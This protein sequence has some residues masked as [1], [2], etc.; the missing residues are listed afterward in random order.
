MKI[1][2]VSGFLGAGKTTFIEKMTKKIN[3]EFVV[4]ENEYGEVGIDGD[5]LKRDYDKVWEMTEGCIC[6]SMKSDF[7]NS[8]MTIS[9]AVDPDVLIVEPTGVGMLSSVMNNIKKVEYDRIQILEPIT[10]VDPNC[11][12]IYKEEF[13]D[14][15]TDQIKSSNMIIISK[16]ENLDGPAIE[17]AK[18]YVSDINPDAEIFTGDYS[19]YDDIWWEEILQK[20]W[21]SREDKVKE[22]FVDSKIENI[23]FT[24]VSFDD[25]LSFQSNMAAVMRGRFGNVIR[26][27]GFLKINDVWTKLDIVGN[28]YTLTKIEPMY[29]SKIIL[30]G[31]DLNKEELTILF[32]Q[33]ERE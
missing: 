10:I 8:V 9:N 12:D 23:G 20:N 26:A 6:C 25:L 3:R 18:K 24:N 5:L 32:K 29:N 28:T 21:T 17:K 22:G 1:L 31:T 33:N 19:R 7:A 11:I 4:L 14:I 2:V 27:K 15:F 30:I 13:G 16:T